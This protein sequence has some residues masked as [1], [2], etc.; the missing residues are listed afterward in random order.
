MRIQGEIMNES[1]TSE[2]LTSDC[3]R[4]LPIPFYGSVMGLCGLAIA[5]GH[6]TGLAWAAV[7]GQGLMHATAVWF[8]MLTA[9][10]GVK[11]FRFPE[12]VRAEFNH[13]VRMN[14]FPAISISL[15]LFSIGYLDTSRGLSA[16]LWYAGAVLHLVFLLRTL[17]V[18]I[19]RSAT[20]Q[21]LNPAWFIPVVGTLLAPLAGVHHA[22]VEVSW[23][24]FSIGIV[25]WLVLL[26]MTVNRIIF[27]SGLPPKLLPTLF[28]LI[29]PPAVGF[30]SYVSLAE[31]LDAIARVL[32]F[33][34]IFTGLMV[35]TFADRF[36]K[37]PFYLSWWAYTFPVAALSLATFRY[38]AMTGRDGFGI[39][40]TVLVLALVVLTTVIVFRTAR[41]LIRGDLCLPEI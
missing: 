15:L 38:Q 19:F 40:G 12:E 28:I 35:L 27:E 8:L 26:T 30:L 3:I 21:S 2:V 20:V 9:A 10:Y 33:H 17:R 5:L 36:L 29:A 39:L 13:P 14:F 18:W 32:Y 25:F 22:P 6:V 34:A 23:F 41:A 11:A 16:G 24:F 4:H 1:S 37:V 31:E 7:A